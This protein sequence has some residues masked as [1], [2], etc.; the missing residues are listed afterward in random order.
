MSSA[1]TPSRRR[2]C[3]RLQKGETF[4]DF[5]LSEA[6]GSW[7]DNVAVASLSLNAAQL[8]STTFHIAPL[9]STECPLTVLRVT[10]LRFMSLQSQQRAARCSAA[11]E[12]STQS[13]LLFLRPMLSPSSLYKQVACLSA[14][15]SRI[16]GVIN[17]REFDI[18]AV[19]GNLCSVESQRLLGR[20]HCLS[21][22]VKTS[23][24]R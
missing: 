18:S 13:Q 19:S 3:R 11:A 23:C 17:V 22:T 6:V 14:I 12:R 16:C 21:W 9:V 7:K 4:T 2:R 8:H 24:V 5:A 1:G 20:M 10:L 15:C